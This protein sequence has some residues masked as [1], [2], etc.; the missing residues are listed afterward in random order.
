V[1][2][3]FKSLEETRQGQ[4]D[5]LGWRRAEPAPPASDRVG[6]EYQLCLALCPAAR[7]R[8]VCM[9]CVAAGAR[10]RR[11]I[12]SK[13]SNVLVSLSGSCSA[14]TASALTLRRRIRS[15]LSNSSVRAAALLLLVILPHL[16]GRQRWRYRQAM[17]AL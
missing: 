1:H 4:I 13:L 17:R 6:V 9:V 5:T 16:V 2:H 10:L 15:K 14:G 11:R 7:H 3:P 8:K 12:R